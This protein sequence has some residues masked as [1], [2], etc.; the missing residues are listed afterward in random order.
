MLPKKSGAQFVG[1]NRLGPICLDRTGDSIG[2]NIFFPED[3][4]VKSDAPNV[5]ITIWD[6]LT[7][8]QRLWNTEYILVYNVS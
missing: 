3:P 7:A 6:T 8:L 2:T 1:E 4:R 5:R